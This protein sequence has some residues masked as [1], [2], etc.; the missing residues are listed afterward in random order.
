MASPLQGSQQPPSPVG[1]PAGPR[2]DRGLHAVARRQQRT[3]APERGLPAPA[4]RGTRGRA[5]TDTAP[6]SPPHPPVAA[7]PDPF[8]RRLSYK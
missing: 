4:R 7:G 1:S 8:T 5:R 6:L 2:T 3:A